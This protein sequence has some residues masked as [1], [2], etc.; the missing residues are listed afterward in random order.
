M[1]SLLFMASILCLSGV[2]GSISAT[3]ASEDLL[4]LILLGECCCL[5]AS[6]CRFLRVTHCQY[7]ELYN[8][9]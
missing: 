7:W 8:H 3:T 1:V 9:H 6:I 4:L 2:N 5:S